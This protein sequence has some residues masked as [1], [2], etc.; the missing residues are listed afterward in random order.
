MCPN[1]NVISFN[2]KSLVLT[3][4]W[5]SD[6]N[7]QA[8]LRSP[9][10]CLPR[11]SRQK[12]PEEAQSPFIR[13]LEGVRGRRTAFSK[14]KACPMGTAAAEDSADETVVEEGAGEED[15]F[16]CFNICKLIH[17]CSSTVEKFYW[18]CARTMYNNLTLASLQTLFIQYAFQS[19]LPWHL[20][21]R[22]E[23]F[24]I[25]NV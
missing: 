17:L 5:F 20:K 16:R 24:L 9:L 22:V 10:T 25:V 6:E 11:Q 3:V 19:L 21:L 1:N 8:S 13:R 12:N 23:V 18:A 2:L 7:E 4:F 14:V 15:D